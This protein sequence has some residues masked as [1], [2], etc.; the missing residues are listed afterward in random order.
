MNADLITV[1]ELWEKE[2]GIQREVLLSAIQ[3]ALVAAA[4]KSVGP[5]RQL[6]VQVDPKTGSTRAWATLVVT[7]KV[8]SRHDQISVFDARR[9]GYP[10]AK[11]GDEVEVEVTPRDFG[12]IAAQSAKHTLLE[13]V[14]KQER[15]VIFDEF[16]DRVGEIVPGT[17]RRFERSDVI[18]EMGK[19]EAIM[20]NRERVP[21]EEYQIGDRVRCLIKSVENT[22]RGPEII[23]S[24]AAPDFVLELFRLEVS[25]IAD[26][27]IEVKGIA[28]DPGFR[29]KLAVF[30]RDPKVDPVGACVGLRGQRVKNIVRELN[31]E[32][33][34]IIPWSPDIRQF[35]T[36]AL[37]PARLRNFQID[38]ANRRVTVQCPADQLSIA[39]GKKGQNTKLTERITGWHISIVP[40]NE[41]ANAFETQ[42]QHAVD[43]LAHVPG[44][45]PLQARSL[46]NAGFHSL[47]EL[48]TA[49]LPDIEAIP[50]VGPSASIILE[51]ARGEMARRAAPAP[52]LQANP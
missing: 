28:R 10:E 6:R 27:T 35:I 2:K 46:V 25:E 41:P 39:I 51:A 15:G 29:T 45:D 17:V 50:G 31:G 47:E 5:A 44:I 8:L 40:E 4:K 19:A 36:E 14:R 20:P 16:K 30:S 42:V 18:V 48:A 26:R 7:E 24:R 1:L 11:V 38:E 52:P 9:Q 49:D 34:D 3:E 21:I 32:K 33:V 23:L 13:L 12:R 37:K 43:E 22:S